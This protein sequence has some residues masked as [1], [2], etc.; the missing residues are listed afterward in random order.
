[1]SHAFQ[2]RRDDPARTRVAAI[3]AD[4][5]PGEARLEVEA[6]ALTANTVTYAV[7]GEAL[8]YWAFYPA[9]DGWGHVPAWGVG[10]VTASRAADLAE[11]T[12][13][14]GFLTMADAILVTPA[15]VGATGFND[16]TPHR[17]PLPAAYNR[18]RLWHDARDGD[19]RLAAVLQPLH[20]TAFLLDDFLADSGFFGARTALVSSASSKTALAIAHAIRK[21]ADRPEL[22]GLTS[23]AN[24]AFTRAT[25]AYDTVLPYPEATGRDPS[26]P[27]IYLDIA[28]DRALRAAIHEHWRDALRHSAAIG[29][30]HQ[31]LGLAT[32]PTA[33]PRPQFFFAPTW[34]AR[35]QSDWGPGSVA[36]RLELAWRDFAAF[37]AGW[38][39]IVDERGPEAVAA[40]WREAHAGRTRPDQGIVL[41]LSATEPAR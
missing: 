39:T 15:K 5:A 6:F 20:A 32:A 31:N 2:V 18:Y 10:T 14:Y 35:R 13:V 25:A 23:P 27:A 12:R 26:E 38:L 8:G 36:E 3:A 17:L 7:H 40:R 11:G 24:L 21:R 28:G 16:A 1:M 19:P 37:A 34:L 33:G 4:P 9:A 29:D 41:A 30:T 22:V